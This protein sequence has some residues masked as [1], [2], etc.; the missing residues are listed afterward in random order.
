MARK[1]KKLHWY[2]YTRIPGDGRDGLGTRKET[3]FEERSD[4]AAKRKAVKLDS[5][6]VKLN[7]FIVNPILER[8]KMVVVRKKE[9]QRER[10]VAVPSEF[11]HSATAKE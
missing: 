8:G 1:N 11:S 9:F 3:I 6:F 4:E 7:G 5:Q 10:I 2:R